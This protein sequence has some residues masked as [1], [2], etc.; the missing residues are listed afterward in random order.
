[1]DKIHE[2]NQGIIMQIYSKFWRMPARKMSL[3]L[4]YCSTR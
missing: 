3:H 1:L 2:H 4:F